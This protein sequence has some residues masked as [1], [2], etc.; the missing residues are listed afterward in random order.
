MVVK[1]GS[2]EAVKKIENIEKVKGN[3]QE[4]R[5]ALRDKKKKKKH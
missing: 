1:I 4:R 2:T 3:R 5:K